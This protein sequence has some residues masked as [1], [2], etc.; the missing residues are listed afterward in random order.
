[1][2][3]SETYFPYVYLPAPYTG[4]FHPVGCVL[5]RFIYTLVPFIISLKILSSPDCEKD[6][7]CFGG[8]GTN[9][10][11]FHLLGFWHRCFYVSVLPLAALSLAIKDQWVAAPW[12]EAHSRTSPGTNCF[13]AGERLWLT[14]LGTSPSSTNHPGLNENWCHRM[15]HRRVFTRE[16]I[17]VQFENRRKCSRRNCQWEVRKMTNTGKANKVFWTFSFSCSKFRERCQPIFETIH[18][19]KRFLLYI[20]DL[21]KSDLGSPFSE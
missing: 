9:Q 6:R 17:N 4:A 5:T 18:F 8:G 10:A 16:P 15:L 2:C 3:P 12:H 14:P 13:G 20:W 21:G 19:L 11:I 7:D 1:M